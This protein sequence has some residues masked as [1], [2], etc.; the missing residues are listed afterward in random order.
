[1]DALFEIFKLGYYS[2]IEAKQSRNFEEK[3][4]P[5]TK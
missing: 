5:D 4:M 3:Y 2:L 1:M